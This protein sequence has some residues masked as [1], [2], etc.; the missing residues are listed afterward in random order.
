MA[1]EA[2]FKMKHELSD[3]PLKPSS[4]PLNR[5]G[6][7]VTLYHLF[8]PLESNADGFTLVLY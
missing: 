3:L 7:F 1:F 5:F 8:N 6:F 4:T 2:Q